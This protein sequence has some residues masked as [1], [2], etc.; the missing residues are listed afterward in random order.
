MK[1]RFKKGFAQFLSMM[2]VAIVTAG[3]FPQTAGT[4]K[5]AADKTITGLGTGAIA[6]PTPGAGGWSYVYYGS[7]NGSSVKYRVLDNYTTEF[8]SNPTML[9]DC[10]TIL[11][12]MAADD[13]YDW[14]EIGQGTV[15]YPGYSWGT[16]TPYR[17]LNG[18]DFYGN[19]GVF[20]S[21]EKSAIVASTKTDFS[22]DGEVRGDY[23][24]QN[25]TG[26]HVFLLDAKEVNR[27]DY[28]YKESYD[29]EAVRIKYYNGSAYDWWLRSYEDWSESLP[30]YI[31]EDAAI[32]QADGGLNINPAVPVENSYLAG[33]S[34]AFNVDLS[35]VIF[36]SLISGTSGNSGAEYKLTLKDANMSVSVTSGSDI[37]RDGDVITVPY[38]ISG[39][40]AGEATQISVVI[41][42]TAWNLGTSASSGY[43]YLKLNV[44]TWGTSGVGTF[45]LPSA[46]ADKVCG[47][48]YYAYILA[49]D[50]RG[51]YTTDYASA[52]VA[53]SIPSA[54]SNTNNNND[55]NPASNPSNGGNNNP[56]SIL[57][58][59]GN[60]GPSSNPSNGGN[61]DSVP[62]SPN[63][64]GNND[65]A[66]NP[67]N[68]GNNTPSSNPSN[69]GN[70]TPSSSGNGNSGSGSSSGSWA[71]YGNPDFYDDLRIL[72]KEAIALGGEQTIHYSKGNKLPYDIMKSLEDHPQITVVYKYSYMD[73]DYTATID[74]RKVKTD[75]LVYWYGP[76]YLDQHF[77]EWT[78]GLDRVDPVPTQNVDPVPQTITGTYVVKAGDTLWAIAKEKHTNVQ[79]LMTMN[80]IK[81]PNSIYVGQVLNY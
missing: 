36:S 71:G 62:P 56:A 31:C 30:N 33:V 19:A 13:A 3:I 29:D 18:S 70:N 34:P 5:A 4:V 27:N 57:S 23:A 43:T 38:T 35:S 44:Q 2:L 60:N 48:D 12:V 41:K 73:K 22:N 53:I 16:S 67:S 64:G 79:H 55:P 9:L 50:V 77:G 15:T 81:N 49:E 37:T 72:I 59:G 69:G 32:I 25:L 1:K 6:N 78:L 17:W 58:N 20:T 40:N 8:G 52:P 28:G 63:N 61:N 26:E 46:Y 47:T 7:Y 39:S 74:G 76:L 66:S 80:N 65:P 24:S 14:V 42:D 51:G 54:T 75:I 11:A 45:T 21:V 10:D 68:G